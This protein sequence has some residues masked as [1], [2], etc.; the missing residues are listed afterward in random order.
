MLLQR[1]GR[2]LLGLVLSGCAS[3][4]GL[5]EYGP[6]ERSTN[7]GSG[8]LGGGSEDGGAGATGATGPGGPGGAGGLGGA[9]GGMGGAVGCKAVFVTKNEYELA[10]FGSLTNA[11]SLCGMVAL[12]KTEWAA[13]LSS[14]SENAKD[15][16][17]DGPWCLLDATATLVFANRD[18]LET[19]PTVAID[20]T[21]DGGKLP[22]SARV[23]TGTS[24][25]GTKAMYNCADWTDAGNQTMVGAPMTGD[26]WTAEAP[27]SACTSKYHLYCF[28]K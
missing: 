19:G 12:R 2:L 22:G 28:E 23:W 18:Q 27:Q 8:G 4:A 14:T 13:W 3:L 17:G 6:G 20:V 21:E 1:G 11:D 16:V 26:G 9:S 10:D 5:G 15:R 25:D 7:S 24:S